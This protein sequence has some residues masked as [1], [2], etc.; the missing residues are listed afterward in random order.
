M[1]LALNVF[2]ALTMPM[3]TSSSPGRPVEAGSNLLKNPII[4]LR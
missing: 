3:V 4:F 2:G 1:N